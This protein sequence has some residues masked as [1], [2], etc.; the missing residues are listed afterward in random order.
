MTCADLEA[1]EV[2]TRRPLVRSYHGYEVVTTPPP[3]SGG[4]AVLQMLGMLERFDL[5]GDG[6]EFGA[7]ATLNVMMEAMR[8]A[9]ADRAVARRSRPR[10]R[11]RRG[12]VDPDY[13][14]R[15]RR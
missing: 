4:V 1:Y 14:D 8:L 15:A 6:F 9:F 10:V 3:S 5:G 11:A 12:A 7:A 13:L 2:R